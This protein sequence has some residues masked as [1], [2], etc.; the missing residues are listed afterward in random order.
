MTHVLDAR[1][2][3]RHWAPTYDAETVVSALEAETFDAAGVPT[4]GA[5]VLDVG[6]GTGRRNRDG[7]GIDVSI[8]MLRA[9]TLGTCINADARFLPVASAIFD[10]VWCRLMIGHVQDAS[11]VYGELRRV[12][13][14]G[15]HVL[16]SDVTAEATAAGHRRT[17][18]D[19][20]G[21]VR[22]VE[23][24]VHDHLRLGAE[25]G[26]R[27]DERRRGVIGASMAS[28]YMKA[29]ASEMYESQRGTPLVDV[30]RFVKP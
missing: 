3:Y 22:E 10:V 11:A 15:G 4:K 9:G 1:E 29:G 21:E 20:L 5:R 16:V 17:F 28:F 27:L 6:C 7:I 26:L 18:R 30:F 25:S 12:C 14:R 19:R 23:H 2:A 8:D 13:R 24:H